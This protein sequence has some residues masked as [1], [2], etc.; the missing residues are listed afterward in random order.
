M[1]AREYEA[2]VASFTSR[3][4]VSVQPLEDMHMYLCA[5][6]Y[7]PICGCR[8]ACMYAQYIHTMWIFAYLHVYIYMHRKADVFCRCLGNHSCV[9]CIHLDCG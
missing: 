2:A 3:P 7:T 9:C 5:N 4:T 1:T 6:V 8:Y